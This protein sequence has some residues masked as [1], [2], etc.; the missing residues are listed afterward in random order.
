[1][2]WSA[3]AVPIFAADASGAIN[4]WN[5]K[6]SEVTGLAVEQAMGKPI[7]DLVEE[8][9]A[10]NMLALALKGSE[11]RGAEIRIRAF[12]PKR[13]SS[14]IDLVVNTCCSRDT[15]NNVLGVCFIGQDVTGQKTL[16]ENYS[17]VKE[18][19]PESCGTLPHSFYLFL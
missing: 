15:M 4:G 12:G 9:S 1:M 11:E 17:R 14:P 19:M 13:K 2:K 8:D 3:T 5:S 10:K 18:I 6:A 16:I 7:S